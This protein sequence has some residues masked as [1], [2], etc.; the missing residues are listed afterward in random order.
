MDGGW[1]RVPKFTVRVVGTAPVWADIEVEAENGREAQ[2]KASESVDIPHE[3]DWQR[4]DG[5]NGVNDW[6]YAEVYDEDGDE[7]IDYDGNEVGEEEDEY[8]VVVGNVGTVYSGTSRTEALLRFV[9]YAYQSQQGVG[10][11]SAEH[12]ALMCNDEII[13][14]FNAA[15]R[16]EAE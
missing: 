12:I 13:D 9:S 11:A 16:E 1:C 15:K 8:E 3:A 5:G 14:E 6:E 2:E 10:R 4:C 7:V